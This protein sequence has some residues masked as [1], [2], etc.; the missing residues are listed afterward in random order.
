MDLSGRKAKAIHI[1]AGVDLIGSRTSA[2]HA[3][4]DLT[5]TNQG[6]LIVSRKTKR[7]VLIPYANTKGIELLP[8]GGE[9]KA[10]KKAKA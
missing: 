8:E 6:V 4:A 10:P 1:H 7:S 5:L 2:S 9:V 3:D